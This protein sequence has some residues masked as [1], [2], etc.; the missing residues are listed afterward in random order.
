[1]LWDN[2]SY[3]KFGDPSAAV[4]VPGTTGLDPKAGA[5]DWTG[6]VTPPVT[7]DYTFRAYSSGAIKV[8]VAG[9]IVIDHWRQGWLPNE[10]VARVALTAGKPV[11]V[12]LQWKSDIGVK[13]V[14]L[15]WKPP[16]ANRTTSLW[17]EVA[18][19]VDYHFV[20]GPR[21]D[22]VIAGYRT[23]TGQ[24]AMLPKWAFGFW[25]S[26]ERYRSAKE[27]LEVVKGYRDRGWPLDV[28]V[29]DWRYWP[30]GTWGSHQFDAQRF[31]DPVGLL[32]TVHDSYQTKFMISVWPKFHTG[33]ANF[34][35]LNAAG[36]LYQPNL[37]EK[38]KD[39]V[40]QVFTYYD[41]FNPAARAAYWAQIRD[42]LWSKGVDA[43]WMDAT[44]PEVV[45][46]PFPSVEAQVRTNQT[47]MHPTAMGTGA[48]ML[49]AYPLMNSQAIWDGQRAAAPQKPV[50]ILTRSAFA[51]QQRF[52]AITWSGD[53]SSTWTAFRKQI[54]AGL[55]FA[56]SGMPYW[57]VD[58]GGFSVPPWFA[59]ARAGS[60]ELDEWRELNTRWF[61]YVT[62]LPIMRVHGQLPLR[63]I[64]QFGGDASPHAQAMVKFDRLRYRLM[65]YIESLATDVVQRGGTILRPL[66][67]D[68]PNDPIARTITDAYMFGPA[69]LV[70]PVTTH[71][72]RSRAVYLPPGV[73]W[74]DFWTG[75]KVETARQFTAAAPLDA[76]PIF[77]R[78]D[79]PWRGRL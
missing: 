72:A 21:L 7:G 60:K 23:L 2:T 33:T 59:H 42:A 37:V 50:V 54:P 71:G 47:H 29:Q 17:S 40:G 22:D 15:L 6:T 9:Q 44:E 34:D 76:I 32:R 1:V 66:V 11:K 52:G 58:G 49:N 78:G 4:P 3:S 14:R 64:W 35:A 51:G 26:R 10:D 20:Y 25:Q 74:Y 24:A 79:S 48:R 30:E 19:G 56:L 31:P 45:E 63:E 8:E 75:R 68:F 12:R 16:V 53:I 55:S 5:I 18:D 36:F 41:A 28:I 67:M 43:W 69:L 57:A 73:D 13:I 27:V 77:V 61:Q 65:P 39:F 62:F 70:A 38:K 46:G